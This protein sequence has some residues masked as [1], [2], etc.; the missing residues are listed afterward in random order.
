MD[1]ARFEFLKND[2][3]K[4][5]IT[6]C[7]IEA[8]NVNFGKFESRLH[9]KNNHLQQDGFV[10]AGLIST[11]AD[12]TA[13]YAAYTT[14][15]TGYRILTVEFKINF[16]KPAKGNL[17]I[18]RSNVIS[19][20]KMIKVVE[21]DVYAINGTHEKHV[22]KGMFTMISVTRLQDNDKAGDEKV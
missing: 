6:F 16:M 10:H 4:G 8:T 11:M 12:H 19:N 3:S 7:G 17:I 2:F 9:I 18:C 13:G 21:S 22:S 1:I 15:E 14:V 20:G 5:F